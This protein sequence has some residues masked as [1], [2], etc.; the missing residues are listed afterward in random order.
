MGH[1]LD[2]SILEKELKEEDMGTDFDIKNEDR[3]RGV[4]REAMDATSQAVA[5][6]RR[7]M[8]N[9]SVQ[10]VVI[11]RNISIQTKQAAEVSP[12]ELTTTN[13][14]SNFVEKMSLDIKETKIEGTHEIPLRLTAKSEGPSS[15]PTP[16]AVTATK[17]AIIKLLNALA[18]G[19][20]QCLWHQVRSEL[21]FKYK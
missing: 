12:I 9:S 14:T 7:F 4:K 10:E 16:E 11:P 21:D 3:S 20:E 19:Q 1:P 2:V 5:V 6:K 18:P 15:T 8:E 13:S 17:D